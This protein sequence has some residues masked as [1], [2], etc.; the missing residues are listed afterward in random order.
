[1]RKVLNGLFS[2]ILLAGVGLLGYAGYTHIDTKKQ[3][4]AAAMQADELL[5]DRDPELVATASDELTESLLV[6]WQEKER[7]M[8]TLGQGEAFGKL[9]L[10]R[11]GG[12][13]PIVE[14]V[15]EDDLSKGV[16]HDAETLLPLDNGQTVLSGHRDTVFR[17][18]GELEIGDTMIVQLPYGDFEYRIT[19]TLIVD[20][21]DRTVIVPHESETL[22]VTTCYPFDFVGYAPDRYII[23][24]EP[25][26]DMGELE[27]L[28]VAE[29]E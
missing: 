15:D 27:A 2:V 29:I 5:A 8:P 4:D 28:K 21:D 20:A 13:L 7:F 23:H 17:G 18:I 24:A 3:E 1:M 12:E 26:F 19:E 11:I 6:N 16:G 22:T 10:P 25:T 14:G 9:L